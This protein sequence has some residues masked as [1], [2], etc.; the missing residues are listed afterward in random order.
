MKCS[1]SNA[2]AK[3]NQISLPANF[4]NEKNKKM[5]VKERFFN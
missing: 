5:K 4:I 1:F 3:I 2:D